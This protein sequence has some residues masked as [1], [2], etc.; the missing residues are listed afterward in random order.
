MKKKKQKKIRKLEESNTFENIG[1]MDPAKES[2]Y[3]LSV[4][5]AKSIKQFSSNLILYPYTFDYESPENSTLSK[6]FQAGAYICLNP[7][8]LDEYNIGQKHE[9]TFST[10][11]ARA[12]FDSDFPF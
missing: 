5:I 2:Q 1:F 11:R 6:E 3:Y 12:V 4:A 8:I 9:G 10:K 7:S